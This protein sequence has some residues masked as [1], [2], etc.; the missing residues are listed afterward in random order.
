MR[1]ELIEDRR[2]IYRPTIIPLNRL[3]LKVPHC[4]IFI[5]TIISSHLEQPGP[6]VSPRSKKKNLYRQLSRLERSGPFASGLGRAHRSRTFLIRTAVW[7]AP[8]DFQRLFQVI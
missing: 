5:V 2:Q 3:Q 7:Y 8:G 1:H 4:S 6:R